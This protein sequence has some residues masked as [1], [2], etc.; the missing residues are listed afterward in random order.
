MSYM[1]LVQHSDHEQTKTNISEL[2]QK[3][4]LNNLKHIFGIERDKRASHWLELLCC[5][6][7]SEITDHV[8]TMCN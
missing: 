2:I 8:M 1:I 3:H 5:V 6:H 7:V 4:S